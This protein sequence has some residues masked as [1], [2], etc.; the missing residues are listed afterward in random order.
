MR[1]PPAA[2]NDNP[3]IQDTKINI[4]PIKI[5]KKSDRI[6]KN[7]AHLSFHQIKY[8]MAIRAKIQEDRGLA[9]LGHVTDPV[10]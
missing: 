5:L 9:D 3:T 6:C 10:D 1:P 8:G 4:I 2:G 7:S